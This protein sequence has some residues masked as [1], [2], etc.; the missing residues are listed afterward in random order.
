MA[1]LTPFIACTHLAGREKNPA[2]TGKCLLRSVTLSRGAWLMGL[3]LNAPIL[4]QPTTDLPLGPDSVTGYLIFHAESLDEAVTV[5]QG[6]PI[7]LA[8]RVYEISNK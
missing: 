4:I 3:S 6:C 5:A 2:P 7:V 8:N 1:K